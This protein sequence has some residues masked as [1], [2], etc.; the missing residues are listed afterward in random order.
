[1]N[2]DLFPAGKMLAF[3]RDEANELIAQSVNDTVI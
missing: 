2:H 3:S 1:M